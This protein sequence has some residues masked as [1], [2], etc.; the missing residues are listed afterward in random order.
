MKVKVIA[1]A[2][3]KNGDCPRPCAQRRRLLLS[4]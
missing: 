1:Q 2:E 4:S 3:V